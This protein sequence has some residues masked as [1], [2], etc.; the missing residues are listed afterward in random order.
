MTNIY[1]LADYI[2]TLSFTDGDLTGYKISIG[3]PAEASG[4]SGADKNG[5]FIGSIVVSRT[6][7]AWSLEGDVTGGF[8]HNRNCSRIG[9]VVIQINQVSDKVRA[10]KELLN[11]YEQSSRPRPFNILVTDAYN[12]SKWVAKCSSCLIRKIPNQ[13]FGNTAAMQDWTFNAGIVE[14]NGEK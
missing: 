10:L 9:E 12:S 13:A 4:V 8:V 6:P 5:G 1:S 14:F 3:G 7:E 11:K 2:V